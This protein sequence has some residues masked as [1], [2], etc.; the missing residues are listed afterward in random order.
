MQRRIAGALAVAIVALATACTAGPAQGHAEPAPERAP[1]TVAP[2]PRDTGGLSD[3]Q[4]E[5]WSA[6]QADG[7]DPALLPTPLI[8]H[9]GTGPAGFRLP[10]LDPADA[11]GIRIYLTCAVDS[12][13]RAT[14]G[15]F[16][17]GTC[18]ADGAN[19]GTLPLGAESGILTLEV[20]EGTD[21][22]L[23]VVPV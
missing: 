12:D 22:W 10:A 7:V 20:P 15:T 3:P 1:A 14:Y 6:A 16:Y 13:F 9:R 8:H 23:L 21:Y 5:Y 18:F 2:S 4:A 11:S 19:S 17:A